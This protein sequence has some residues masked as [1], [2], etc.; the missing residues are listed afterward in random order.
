MM[1]GE[2]WLYLLAVLINAVNLFLQVFFTIM[3]SD[4][5]C[6]YINPIDLC[7]R[8]NTYIVPEAAVQA[9][10][11]V[12]F[13]IN[14]YWIALVLNLPLLAYNAKKIFENQHLLDAT[15]IFRKLNV[16]KKESFI[17]LGFHLIMFFFYLYSMI[18]AMALL[19]AEYASSDEGTSPPRQEPRKT[20]ASTI[21]AAPEVSLD[22]PMRLQMMLAKPTDTDLTY[23]VPYADLTRPFQ[24]PTNPFITT[25]GN[26]LKRK[27]VLTGYAEEAAIS[28][29]T[30]ANQHRTFQSRGYAQEPNANGALVGDLASAEKYGGRNIVQLKASRA[31]RQR[32]TKG[33]PSIVDGE[34]RY[35]GPWAKYQED[36]QYED[37]AALAEEELASDEEYIDESVAPVN[38]APMSK[39][40]TN[41]QDDH[42]NQETTEFHGSSL[43]DYQ[44]RSYMH[45]PRD[46]D[47]DLYKEQGLERTFHPKKLIHTWKHGTKPINALRFIPSTNHLL[48]SASAD[49]KIKI[50][51]VYRDRELLRTYSGHTK[52]VSDVN[53]NPTGTQFLSGSYDRYMKIWDTETGACLSRFKSGAIPHCIKFNPSSPH[54]FLAGMSDKKIIQYDTRSGEMTQ[55]YDHHLG[56][57]NTITFVDEDRRFIT[58]SDDKS[59][60]AW[61]LNIPVPIKFI[62]EPHMFALTAAAPHPSGK[63]VCFQSGDNKIVVYAA[64]DRFRQNRKKEFRGHN[65]SGYAIDI[66]L[67]ANGDWVSS[68]D[69]GGWVCFWDY[70]TC[71][72]HHKIRAG[73]GAI[74]CVQWNRQTTSRVAT[75][76]LEGIIKYWD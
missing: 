51:D 49:A 67:S 23:N 59:L 60:R 42:S 13:L 35:M 72:M 28:D 3:Y 46:I 56:P 69:S 2:A 64:T 39:A 76:G 7:N 68:G 19:G 30:F 21:I 63:S 5:E 26:A 47:V 74:T 9:F 48:L 54:E 34:G 41:Y 29:A 61:E 14:G 17:K 44:G 20:A 55:E 66:D 15:E 58:T 38:M 24:G 16:H 45:A 31:K 22:D 6:D 12:L 25:E 11:T 73:E 70:K 27:N 1:S 62:A 40:A 71:K 52:S 57:I 4:L 53:F 65:T 36:V 75:A 33:D 32:Q 50:F 8:L 10:L 18:T 43:I 37:E